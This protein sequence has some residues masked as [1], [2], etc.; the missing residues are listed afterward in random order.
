MQVDSEGHQAPRPSHDARVDIWPE[1]FLRDFEAKFWMTYRSNFPPIPRDYNHD[2]KS[3][4]TLGVRLRSQLLDPHGFTSDTGWGCMIR[5]GQSLL[6]NAMAT[7]LLGRG[8]RRSDGIYEETKLLSLFADSPEAPFSIHQFVGHGA[9]F[10]G[11]CPGE[12]FGPSATARCIQALSKK[13]SPSNLRVYV[14]DDNSDVYQD[15]F[16]SVSRNEQGVVCPTLILIGTRLGID[17]VTPVYWD[18]LK[19]VLQFPQSVGIAGG[20]PSASHYFIGIQGAQ[21]F[22]LDP[23]HTRPALPYRGDGMYTREEVDTYH[24][25]RLRRIHIQDMDPSMLIGF[26][27]KNGEDWEDWKTRIAST[28][29]KPIINIVH[30]TNAAFSQGRREALDEVETFDDD[31]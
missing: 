28:Q 1:E 14:T 29:G 25:R 31:E 21:F 7:L 12:W 19:S 16:M 3:S 15:K 5:S 20:R 22:Y 23:H 30:E 13:Y 11:K 26:L 10:C 17:H 24:T 27:I 2:R 4:M 8:W 6:A 18:G 9:E